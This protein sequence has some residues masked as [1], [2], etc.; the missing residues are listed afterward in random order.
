MNKLQAILIA[1]LLSLSSVSFASTFNFAA[2]ADGNLAGA[3]AISGLGEAGYKSFSATNDSITVTATGTYN[4]ADAFAYLDSGRAGLGVCHTGLEDTIL[5]NDQCVDRSDDNVTGDE[6]VKLDFGRTVKLQDLDLR[7]AGHGTTFS[8]TFDLLIDGVTL[9][10][11]ALSTTPSDALGL[12]G[13][14]F[15]FINV[16]GG[17]GDEFYINNVAVS[18]VPVPA[19]GILF[20]SALLGA[21]A[22]GRRKKKA[23]ASVVGAFARAS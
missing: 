13:N 5:G 21:G 19:A 17:V 9:I 1:G 22:L 7:N 12:V 10:N 23:Q 20:A 2:Y 6:A 18:A 8:G 4:G 11:I 15:E 14:T 3:T 16:G